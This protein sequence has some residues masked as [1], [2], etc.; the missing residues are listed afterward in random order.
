MTKNKEINSD[1]KPSYSLFVN[2]N[3]LPKGI[4]CVF[5]DRLNMLWEYTGR[6][7]GLDGDIMHLFKLK[8]GNSII[9]QQSLQNCYV[10]EIDY[11]SMRG[12]KEVAIKYIEDNIQK[13]VNQVK[14]IESDILI[15]L[16]RIEN[17]LNF[18]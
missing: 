9:A 4:I 6:Y 14:F 5:D 3:E 8:N 11:I 16:D 7:V 1:C 12:S 15:R 17:Y 10:N 13:L 2:V 18:K